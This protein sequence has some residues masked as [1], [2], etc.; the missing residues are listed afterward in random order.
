MCK[1]YI[2]C[3]SMFFIGIFG[4][5]AQNFGI[6]KGKVSSESG[7][8][9]EYASIVLKDTDFST[10]TNQYGEFEFENVPSNSYTLVVSHAGYET[11]QH[12]ISIDDNQ[13]LT[14]PEIKLSKKIEESEEPE[15]SEKF[16]AIDDVVISSAA[17]IFAEK[18]SDLV[19]RMPLENLENPQVY[20][21]VPKELLTEQIATDF[22]GALLSSP[23]VTNVMLGVGS[24]GTGL[25]MRMRGFAGADGA[26]SV[27]N[28]MATNFVSLS[29]PVNL[30]RLE[31]IKGP[32]STL[33]GS[34]L[35]SYG[36]LVN[37]V[38]KR[39]LTTTKGEVGLTTGAYG[40]GRV[41]V[42]YNTPLKKDKTVLFRIN[43]A[44]QREKSFQDQGINRTVMIAPAFKF[45]LSDDLTINVDFEYFKSER[46][47]TYVGLTSS[48]GITNFD[49]LN[50]DFKKSY[51]SNDITS[52]AEVLNVFADAEYKINE[53]W[54]SDTRVSY[55]NTDNNA[56]YLFLLVKSGTGVYDGKKL[57]QRR[58]MN[59]PSN[60]NTIQFQ[61]NFTGI[62]DWGIFNNKF[63]VGVDYTQLQTNDSRTSINDYDALNGEVTVLNE[64]APVINIDTYK[65][66]LAT[67]SRPSNRRDT[68]TFSAYV[69]DVITWNDRLSIMGGL[70]ID[71]FHDRANDYLQT[72]WSPKLGIVYQ[73]IEKQL[74]LFTNY[75][76]GF[77]NVAPQTLSNNT[78]QMF[79]PEQANQIEAGLK[80]ELM[81]G[82]INGTISYYNI[83]VQ[84]KVRS[85]LDANNEYVS[86]QDGTQK[87]EGIEFDLIANPFKGFHII[88]GYGYNDSR[89]TKVGENESELEGN[90][91]LATP[92]NSANYWASYKIPQGKLQGF[93]FGFGGNLSSDYYFNDTNTVKVSGFHTLDASVFYEQPKFRV[94]L[95]CNNLT[96]EEYWTAAYWA[97]PQQTRTILANLTFKF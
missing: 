46:N 58:I 36:G 37:R 61:Q 55:S 72:A 31:I 4:V 53:H 74:S 57:L 45:L 47:T 71:R 82:K 80:F 77:K 41:T 78:T 79:K 88:V 35:I 75:Q 19:A 93:G 18:K 33:F 44:I 86:V 39:P 81:K 29:D 25:S 89:F 51:A 38:T 83:K 76:N 11:A 94:G 16:E 50:W 91:P 5:N 6:I 15:E 54:T 12:V 7:E 49:E 60:F 43:S 84:D 85:V 87:S 28:G 69:S 32:S 48:A 40:L 2:V 52:L 92:L 64:T 42:D 30:E 10:V 26:G 62:H 96:N 73:V 90:R 20:T 22:R 70:R 17:K 68:Q 34:T 59:L 63:L 9:V 23:G 3:L 1:K 95:K 56:N 13:T 66:A 14:I 21:V 97:I 65:A 24:G 8:P 27:R 67:A